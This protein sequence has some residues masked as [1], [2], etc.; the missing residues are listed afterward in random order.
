MLIP[1]DGRLPTHTRRSL[2]SEAEVPR[3]ATCP[4]GPDAS[5]L[6]LVFIRRTATPGSASFSPHRTHFVR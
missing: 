1:T 4:L 5:H 3:N 2:F 6:S